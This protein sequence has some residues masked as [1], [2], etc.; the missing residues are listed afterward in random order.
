M[1]RKTIGVCVTGFNIEYETRVVEGI[2]ARCAEQDINLLVF[3]SLEHKTALYETEAMPES[4]F[5]GEAEVFNLVNYDMLDGVLVLGESIIDPSVVDRASAEC[6]KRSI[7]FIN[8]N[9]SLHRTEHNVELSDNDSMYKI[10]DHLITKHGCRKIDYISGFK[11]N[12]QS[13]E[14]LDAYKR[15]LADHGIPFEEERVRYGEFWRKASGCTDEL[16]AYDKP[17]AIACANDTMGIFCMER[18]QAH[19]YSVPGD[20][21][22]T[23]FDG[24]IDSEMCIP[25]LTTVRPAFYS[26]GYTAVEQIERLWA[27]EE[28]PQVVYCDSEFVPHESC[29]CVA[30]DRP[31]R[32]SFYDKHYADSDDFIQLNLHI[33]SM[34]IRFSSARQAAELYADTVNGADFF[35]FEKMFICIR[36]DI[37][38]YNDEML[39]D[40][41]SD[42]YK[43]IPDKVVSMVQ[44]GH[45]VPN[46]TVFPTKELVPMDILN[47][48]KAVMFAF[49][50]IY[51]N[52]KAL[53]YI[54]YEPKGFGRR[55]QYFGNWLISI[56]NNAGSFY[57]KN[58]LQYIANRLADLHVRDPLT[59]LYNRRG[60]DKSLTKL[61]NQALE[62]DVTI[63][64]VCA[65][66]DDLKPI[67][68]TYGHEGGDK[69]ILGV[70]RVIRGCMPKEAVCARTGGDEF[71]AVLAGASDEA[72]CGY[73]E[74]I[75]KALEERNNQSGDPFK[76]GCS[77]GYYTAKLSEVPIET[78]ERLADEAMYRVKAAKKVGRK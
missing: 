65:D 16:L 15:A 77:C 12:L 40:V 5:K 3:A 47:G 20:I 9:D 64:V 36:S 61:M 54:A 35:R 2:R 44:H 50:P 51:F 34:N 10:I 14:R 22:V 32:S 7:P 67:N 56:N 46:G 31:K 55:G 69:A 78:I 71:T 25:T 72:V 48:E 33:R 49:S 60:L 24:T 8:I 29:G 41:I 74:S 19:G 27:G 30:C 21:I 52:D 26:A 58:E 66:V 17:D 45:S 6:K 68:D 57:M 53:G 23:G 37:E 62:A 13:E 63:T 18:V 38:Q 1:A 28:V 4:I 59:S 43:H 70:A 11:V 39:E 73:I 42:G 76:I 75:G